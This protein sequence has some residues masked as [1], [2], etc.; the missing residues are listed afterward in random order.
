MK[1][2]TILCED[3]E[4]VREIFNFILDERGYEVFT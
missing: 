3:N 2:K 4:P 1:Y